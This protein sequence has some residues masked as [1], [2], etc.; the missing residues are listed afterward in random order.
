MPSAPFGLALS[1]VPHASR[2]WLDNSCY[3]KFLQ[4]V[5]SSSGGTVTAGVEIFLS[6][7]GGRL[8]FSVCEDGHTDCG[9]DSAME[10]DCNGGDRR[11]TYD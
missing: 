5:L 3:Y 4:P 6:R 7:G 8:I 10:L 9:F 2:H 1:S 11:V